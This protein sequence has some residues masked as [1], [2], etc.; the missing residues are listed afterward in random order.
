VRTG[1]DSTLI[2]NVIENFVYHLNEGCIGSVSEIFDG[3]F[4][5]SPK[6]CTAQAWGV[7]EILRVIQE[8]DLLTEAKVI[9]QPT[10]EKKIKEDN[11]A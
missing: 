8:Y 7:A 5:Y 9:V 3:E 11:L 4:P 1:T 10:R 2:K 6:G